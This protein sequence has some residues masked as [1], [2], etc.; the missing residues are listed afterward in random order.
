MEDMPETSTFEVT[1]G[2]LEILGPIQGGAINTI[3]TYFGSEED[4]EYRQ[5]INDE[6]LY[7]FATRELLLIKPKVTNAHD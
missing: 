3:L 1:R 2:Q 4:W 5:F 7:A 6:Q